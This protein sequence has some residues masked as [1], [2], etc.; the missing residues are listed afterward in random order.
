M[1]ETPQRGPFLTLLV[2]LLKRDLFERV[3]IPKGPLI[4]T[5]NI[6]LQGRSREL[7]GFASCR[8]LRPPC[9]CVSSVL[10]PDPTL[11]P[12]ALN[13][14]GVWGY[15]HF[16]SQLASSAVRE[17]A[18]GRMEAS[19]STKIIP[20]GGRLFFVHYTPPKKKQNLIESYCYAKVLR[21]LRVQCRIAWDSLDSLGFTA[22][23]SRSRL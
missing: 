15:W 20:W 6:G 18:L 19:A 11:R 22:Y 21:S 23:G 17:K 3:Y 9:A 5:P 14:E 16:P 13:L 4:L 10:S 7:W 1:R 8:T 12:Q 2:A